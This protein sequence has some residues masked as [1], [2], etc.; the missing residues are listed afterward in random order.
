MLWSGRVLYSVYSFRLRKWNKSADA[1]PDIE[2]ESYDHQMS[3]HSIISL[4]NQSPKHKRWVP[5]YLSLD[6]FRSALTRLIFDKGKPTFS[7]LGTTHD[8]A[9]GQ[10]LNADDIPIFAE[11]I[12]NSNFIR[13]RVELPNKDGGI[14]NWDLG[15][16]L[17]R[18]GR[19]DGRAIE[20]LGPFN[21]VRIREA[22]SLRSVASGVTGYL[23]CIDGIVAENEA[24]ETPFAGLL[25]HS[26]PRSRDNNLLN[27][28]KGFKKRFDSLTSDL[29][30]REWAVPPHQSFPFPWKRT[31]S[32]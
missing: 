3:S 24:C 18:R 8:T 29:T 25:A 1:T 15:H 4:G 20:V 5:G 11:S 6:C 13:L 21:R 27:L 10:Y 23:V 22:E 28:S 16:S 30:Y 32:Y 31:R 14:V 7:S 9:L 26:L 2:R 17:N 19:I 12:T